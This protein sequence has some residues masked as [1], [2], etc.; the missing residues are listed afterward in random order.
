MKKVL[1]T[2][3]S[4]LIGGLLREHLEGLEG[5]E[6]SALNRSEVEGVTTHRADISDLDAIKNAFVG[7]D[8]VVHLAAYLGDDDF[9]NQLPVNIIGAY[10]VFEAARLAG[11]KRI[12]YAS[13]GST[14]RGKEHYYPY[15]HIASGNYDQITDEIPI[16]THKE[17]HPGG[18][19]GAMKVWGEALGRHF[20]DEFDISILCVRIGSVTKQNKPTEFRQKSIFLSHK[21]ICQILTLCID[22]PEDLKY[23]IFLAT[24]DNKWNYR[25]QKHA[26]EVLGFDPVDSA[27]RM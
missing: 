3:M 10:N 2:G 1:V 4:G 17:I 9:Y 22:A 14:I 15:S 25:D 11:V 18:V 19:Y 12:V 23:D 20:S 8:V 6:L 26:K 21:D 16:V 5:Y 24:S 27:E 7:V 13:S